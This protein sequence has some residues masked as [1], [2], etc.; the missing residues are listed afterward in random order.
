MNY[1]GLGDYIDK[2]HGDLD[3]NMIYVSHDRVEA[4][5]LTDRHGVSVRLPGGAELRVPCKGEAVRAGDALTLGVRPEDLKLDGGDAGLEG[6]ALA[7]ERLGGET[8]SHVQLDGD[9]LLTA[10]S[11]RT[12]LS[13]AGQPFA[14]GIEAETCHLF[15]ADGRAIERLDRDSFRDPS[16]QERRASGQPDATRTNPACHNPEKLSQNPVRE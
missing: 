1:V 16:Q 3:A 5:T 6:K 15:G 7:L 12:A 4:M 10:K 14:F 11:D 9:N 13:T 8:Y 2:L